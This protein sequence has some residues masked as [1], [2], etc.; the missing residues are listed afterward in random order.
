MGK[1]ALSLLFACLAV[2]LICVLPPSAAA[3]GQSKAEKVKAAVAKLGTGP[4]TRVEVNLGNRVVHKGYVAETAENEF[5]VS[6]PKTGVTVRVPYSQVRSLK[7]RDAAG[8]RVSVSSG[9]IPVTAI[10]GIGAIVTVVTVVALA[11]NLRS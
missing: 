11:L 6:E 3:R 4:D 9:G 10:V 8:Q 5:V 1:K 7:G 2:N